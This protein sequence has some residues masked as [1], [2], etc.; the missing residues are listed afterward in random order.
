MVSEEKKKGK[1]LK[2]HTVA[3]DRRGGRGGEGPAGVGEGGGGED[4]RWPRWRGR[5]R[6]GRAATPRRRSCAPPRP[7]R[8]RAPPSG[9]TTPRPAR[10]IVGD[11]EGQTMARRS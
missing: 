7:P 8:W 3:G 1:S 11:S 2:S 9:A 5:S 10:K 4:R 6:R